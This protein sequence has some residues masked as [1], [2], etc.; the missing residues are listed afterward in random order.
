MKLDQ[1]CN[2][3][4]PE[5]LCVLGNIAGMLS[6][7]IWFM[8]LVPQLIRNHQRRSVEGLN[9]MW[10][11]ANFSASLCNIFFCFRIALPIQTRV[12]AIYMP[13]LE[14]LMLLQFWFY[15]DNQRTASS[16]DYPNKFASMLQSKRFIAVVCLSMWSTVVLVQASFR[17]SSGYFAWCA[18]ALWSFE[19]YPQLWT[20]ISNTGR[21]VSGQSVVSILITIVGKTTDSLSAYLLDMPMQTRVVAF[22]SSTSAWLNA[23]MVMVVYARFYDLQNNT[24]TETMH[25]IRGSTIQGR[26]DA[27][28]E[29]QMMEG[30]VTE[31]VIQPQTGR[32]SYLGVSYC[33]DNFNSSDQLSLLQ[34]LEYG[35]RRS[36]AT[37]Y[38]LRF[39][40][41]TLLSLLMVA[42][43][44]GSFL[45][46]GKPWIV[47]LMICVSVVLVM[48]FHYF[49]AR[50][51][52]ASSEIDD[53]DV[54]A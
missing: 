40:T 25:N 5:S 20:N 19:T 30:L 23:L 33:W 31:T 13:C 18:I 17:N 28:L 36:L 46:I 32:R 4:L 54:A 21:S 34:S 38:H 10:A 47:F 45:T 24:T 8:V 41:A 39:F 3:S 2:R 52:S 15:W 14:F 6:T 53:E 35:I 51:D 11:I 1:N 42:V 9:V 29:L 43:V 22:F 37:S 27:Q 7:A 50:R 16:Q 48:S 44:V 26:D 49:E 12:Q